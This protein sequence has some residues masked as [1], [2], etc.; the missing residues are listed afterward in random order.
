MADKLVS[1][2]DI[3]RRVIKHAESKGVL[4]IR[5]ALQPAVRAGWPD[6]LFLFQGGVALFIEFKATGKRPTPLQVDKLERLK[7]QGFMAHT[8][9]DTLEGI[10]LVDSILK[11]IR[12]IH[13]RLPTH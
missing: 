12:D 4:V 7:V 13:A 2:K 3:Q 8:C 11:N 10:N 9:D 6:V 1:E 5:L